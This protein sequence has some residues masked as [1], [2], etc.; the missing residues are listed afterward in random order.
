MRYVLCPN[1]VVM[2]PE[3]KLQGCSARLV[4]CRVQMTFDA[5]NFRSRP[6]LVTRLCKYF[7]H[8]I[9]SLTRYHVQPPCLET[10]DLGRRK[11]FL[12]VVNVIV[13]YS[14]MHSHCLLSFV[15]PDGGLFLALSRVALKPKFLDIKRSTCTNRLTHMAQVGFCL[16][17]EFTFAILSYQFNESKPNGGLY[18]YTEGF[19]WSSH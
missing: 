13:I 5:N 10:L 2:Q 4:G 12:I 17:D 11:D 16:L 18:P 9:P 15:F 6:C 14:I 7:L 1:A 19:V 3:L 8:P